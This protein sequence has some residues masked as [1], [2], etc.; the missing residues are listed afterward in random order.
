MRRS[1]ATVSLS[2]TLRQKLEAAA[3]ARFD[4]VEL[5]EPDFTSFRGSA[6]EVRAVCEDLGLGID[7][8]QPFRDFEGMPD[9][10]FRRSLDRA[11]RKFDLMQSLGAPMMLVCS[12]VSPMALDDPA[13]A[14]EQ[15]RELAE[16]AARRNLRVGFEALAWGRHVRYWRDAWDIVQAA[17]HPHLGLVLDS[18]H[19]LSLGDDP[20]GIS[21]LPGDRLFFVQMAD[22]P[23]LRLDVIDWARHHR[24]FPGQGQLDVVGFFERVARC[25][26]H[27][28]LS[29][30]I[31]NDVFRET[32]NRRIAVDAMRSLLW[33]ES[34]VRERLEA[35]PDV[36]AR[37]ALDSQALFDPPAMPGFTGFS[38]IEF[39]VDAE[40]GRALGTL[41]ERMGFRRA[42]RHRSK[43]V[44]LYRQAGVNFVVN[45]LAH[46]VAQARFEAYGPSVCAL[47]VR[48]DDPAAARNRATA[49]LSAR[50]DPPVGPGEVVLPSV[51]APGGSIIHFVDEALRDDGLF[52]RDF[53]LDPAPAP[54]TCGL[55]R[56][57]HVGMGLAPDRIDTWVLFCRAVLGLEAG[58]SLKLPDPYGLV[59]SFG[60]A[61]AARRLRFVLNVPLSARSRVAQ[62]VGASGGAGVQV[63]AF[64]SDDIFASVKQLRAA[65]VPMVPVPDNYYDDLATRFDLRPELL[66]RMR[67]HGVLFDRT[68]DGDYFHA[69]TQTF[70]DRFYFE[71]VQRS[72]R[73]DGYGALNAP[74]RM[75]WQA[76]AENG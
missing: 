20:S 73:Y 11:E 57:D 31:F 4:A 42:G 29:L 7:L 66:E 61:D 72:G 65:G 15:L 76:Q 59:R 53:V 64:A 44:T 43:A 3:A 58:D 36:A 54:A 25:G 39:A 46:G 75:A 51:V 70:A 8:F 68:A 41:L 9:A 22:A 30:E 33:L 40:A 60:M 5:F 32:P 24:N 35:A 55:E 74:I 45:E 37:R 69:G 23:R 16:R 63:V 52:E 27:G 71:V 13:L 38:F 17:G 62:V 67:E 2:G 49:L 6:G 12:N 48:V 47:G 14:A 1:I 19:T 34:Q 56:I 10:A 18:F 28:T 26:Y 50:F 21:D